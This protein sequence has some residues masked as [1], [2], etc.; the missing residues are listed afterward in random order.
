[1]TPEYLPI[2]FSR[3]PR[4]DQLP[5]AVQLSK[6]LIGTIKEEVEKRNQQGAYHRGYSH[7]PSGSSNYHYVSG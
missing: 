1:M 3:T 7:A 5:K 4:Q 2:H 6:D